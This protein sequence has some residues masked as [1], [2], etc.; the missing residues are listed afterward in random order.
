MS[1]LNHLFSPIRLGTMDLAN[2]L[3]MP[4]MSINFGVDEDGYLTDQHIEYLRPRAASGTGM[5]TVGGGAVHPDGLDLPRM[6]PIWD[7]RFVPALRRLTEALREY[8]ARIGMQLLHGGRQAFHGNRVAPT[9]LPS[10]GVVKEMP[11]ELENREIK[12]LVSA[13]GDAALRCKRAGFDFVEIHAAHGYLIGE[14]LAPLSNL[15]EDE[16]GG[17]FENR[18]RF[19]LELM[20]DIKAKCGPEYPVGVRYNGDDCI[21]GGFTLEEAVRLGPLLERAGADWLHISAGIYGSF[22]ITIPSLYAE[23]GCFLHLA[24]A[25]KA[26]VGLPVIAVGRI[27]D[28][29]MADRI[30]A[31]GRADLAAMGRA[32]L[33]E[34][35]LAAKA[36]A[37]E[38]GRIRPCLG[39]CKGCIERALALEEA[40]CVMNPALGREYL[41]K[42]R[43]AKAARSKKILV[44][45]AGPA[46][47]AAARLAAKRGHEVVVLDE[48]DQAGGM[49]NLAALAPDRSEF[50]DSVAWQLREIDR[51]GVDLRLNTGLTPE[52][53]SELAPDEVVLASGALPQVPQI[54]GLLDTDL[55]LHTAVDILSGEE[56]AG[57]RSIILGGGMVGLMTADFLAEQGKEALVLHRGDHFAEEMSAN[58]RT[59]LRERLKR[60]EVRLFKKVAI[61][62]F[63]PSGVLIKTGGTEYELGGATDIIIAESMRP[64]R[65][66]AD[67]IRAAGIEPRIIGDARESRTLLE[68]MSEADE[69]GRSL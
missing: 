32:H 46:G 25:V 40:S 60:P 16:Y 47:L 27:K 52:L 53:L 61:Q 1:E 36:R 68:A 67:M 49:I 22:P 51:L 29:V 13:Y 66:A 31:Q 43:P 55:D 14:F 39:C 11:R 69:L 23:H 65:Q 20:A 12:E 50:G 41:L 6:P 58:D 21:E 56:E 59:Y 9:A 10:L 24:E 2:R 19:L 28:P 45:G 33:A 63:E 8:P 30:I 57:Q 54:E 3:V 26:A 17:P 34:P 7:D 38:F 48:A 4:P 62:G 18:I 15:R 5:I 37:G 35:D 42:D 64:I 44:V